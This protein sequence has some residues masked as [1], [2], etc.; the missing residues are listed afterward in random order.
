MLRQIEWGVQAGPITRT[1]FCQYLLYFFENF[2][3]V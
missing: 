1:E 3:S 2:V